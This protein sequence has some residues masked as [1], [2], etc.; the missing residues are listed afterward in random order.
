METVK[1]CLLQPFFSYDCN[2]AFSLFLSSFFF[3]FLSLSHSFISEIL[4]SEHSADLNSA[5]S[6]E[7]LGCDLADL[8]LHANAH[9]CSLAVTLIYLN[10]VCEVEGG[11]PYRSGI[12]WGMMQCPYVLLKTFRAHDGSMKHLYLPPLLLIRPCVLSTPTVC[13]NVQPFLPSPP[14]PV[15]L[16]TRFCSFAL[17]VDTPLHGTIDASKHSY[18]T[19]PSHPTLTRSCPIHTY[20]GHWTGWLQEEIEFGETGLVKAQGAGN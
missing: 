19:S 15:A 7:A 5:I 14:A 8:S 3:L 13:E 1:D 4:P 10:V 20:L 6:A 11:L 12:E 9:S 18:A 17:R 16:S 2:L